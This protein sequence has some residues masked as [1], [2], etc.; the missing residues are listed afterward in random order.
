MT[1]PTHESLRGHFLI[2]DPFMSD[3]N[4]ER[5]IVVLCEHT[6]EGAFGLV[7]NR[8]ADMN[9]DGIFGGEHDFTPAFMAMAQQ[10]A[11]YVGGPVEHNTLH[12]LYRPVAGAPVP[13]S[14]R[15]TD[16]LFWGGDFASVRHLIATDELPPSAIR[17]F[18]GYAGWGAGQ[19]ERELAERSWITT[20]LRTEF[21]FRSANEALWRDV[22]RDMGGRYRSLANYPRDPRLN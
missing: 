1:Q 9:L 5:T 10:H 3:P 16:G 18:A 15:L 11:L 8:S 17:L 22:L 21:V 20:P 19:L 13:D 2:S 14:T 4:F 12:Y 7:L 6:P